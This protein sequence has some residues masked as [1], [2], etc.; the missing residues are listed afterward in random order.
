MKKVVLLGASSFTGTHI[1]SRLSGKY[2]LIEVGRLNYL[3]QLDVYNN[4]DLTLHKI[5][6]DLKDV[7]YVIN[8]ISNG[9]VDFCEENPKEAKIINYDFVKLLVDIQQSYQFHLIHL[10][11]NGVYDGNIPP[12][13]EKSIHNPVNY[14]GK[15][16]S[17]ADK[18]IEAK[19]LK[20]TILRPITMFGDRLPAQRHN[21]FSFFEGQLNDNNDISAVND[22]YVNMLF[23]DDL[24][25]CIDAV[26]EK[27]VEGVFNISGDDILNRVSFVEIIKSNLIDSTSV[28]NSVS[29]D[30]FPALAKRPR[31]TSFNNDKMKFFLRVFPKKLEIIIKDLME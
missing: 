13:D 20:F 25:R 24:V 1:K 29:S 7:D 12:Y 26:I 16:K 11:T 31:N 28:I 22:V 2:E 5:F 23:V 27:E 8:C 4:P 14:Y 15:V 21:P 17:L 9:N 3:Y 6:S 10:S 18:Y 19:S 30:C